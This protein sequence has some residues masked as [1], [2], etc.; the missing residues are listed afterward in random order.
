[1]RVLFITNMYPVPD[2]IYFGIHVKEQIEEIEKIAGIEKEVFFI[3]GRAGK[4]NYWKS[5]ASI[6]QLVKTGKF[7]LIH[8]H[9]G[10]SALFLLF[11]TP[12]I[13][14]VMTLHSGELFKKKGYLNHIIQ[15]NITLAVIEKV[16]K[17]IVLND[18][19]IALLQKHKNKLVKLP[20]GTDIETFKEIPRI[21]KP[22]KMIIGFPGNKGRKEKNYPL[23][24]GII[25]RLRADHE[26]EIIEFH[27]MT[28]EEVII[29]LNTIDLLL[30][31]STIEGSPQ[32]I[33]EAMA[34]NKPIVSTAVGDV[35]DL[36][37]DVKNCF[38]ID[39]FTPG[40]FVTPIKQILELPAE[41]RRSNGRERLSS[42]GL[43]ATSVAR[44]VFKL[45]QTIA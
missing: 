45:Y 31:T 37:D 40:D 34:C 8:V 41:Q 43:D 13:P 21:Q 3:N 18:D 15:K 44:S 12:P 26:I 16:A 33:K 38:V 32:I 6:K 9:Y 1:M 5:I 30:M 10:L 2:Y 11:Y 24:E 22:G 35:R 27:N 4:L 23:F 17:V 39:S 19:M 25:E 14:V 42:I 28:R 7:D 36:L 20:C 29:S